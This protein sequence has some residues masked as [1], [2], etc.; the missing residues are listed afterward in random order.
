V[1]IAKKR[2]DWG[3]L[4]T[5]A[6]EGRGLE[7]TTFLASQTAPDP[8]SDLAAADRPFSDLSVAKGSNAAFLAYLAYDGRIFGTGNRAPH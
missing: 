8:R 6:A 5:I 2:S 4:A 3:K 7:V 1:L